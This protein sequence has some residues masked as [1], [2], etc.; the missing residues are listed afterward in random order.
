MTVLPYLLSPSK[1][2]KK[3][4]K[5]WSCLIYGH[6]RKLKHYF[7]SLL[8]HNSNTSYFS[9]LQNSQEFHFYMECSQ[10]TQPPQKV[11]CQESLNTT[12][13]GMLSSSPKQGLFP[14]GSHCST[15]IY[16]YFSLLQH[17][18]VKCFMDRIYV[19]SS[20]SQKEKVPNASPNLK[21]HYN[22]KINTRTTHTL[23]FGVNYQL[24]RRRK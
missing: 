23:M 15:L 10:L 17:L 1:Q 24:Q 21:D 9:L 7:R 6:D 19:W 13:S 20:T 2:N 18:Y 12:S 3:N 14:L 11:R 16:Q 22:I 5:L 8:F 4:S